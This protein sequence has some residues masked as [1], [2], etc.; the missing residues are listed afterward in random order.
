MNKA[1]IYIHIIQFTQIMYSENDLAESVAKPTQIFVCFRDESIIT[2]HV[3]LLIK[4]IS[5]IKIFINAWKSILG[6]IWFC[7]SSKPGEMQEM[8]GHSVTHNYIVNVFEF[9][10]IIER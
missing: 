10:H 8:Q 3:L 2:K 5:R 6:T 7:H 4:T 1:S 9:I